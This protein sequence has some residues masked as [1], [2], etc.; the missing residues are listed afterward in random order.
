MRICR[1]SKIG[2]LFKFPQTSV[3]IVIT[4]KILELIVKLSIYNQY[5]MY[6]LKKFHWKMTETAV[7]YNAFTDIA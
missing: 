7:K 5:L 3:V 6:F 2:E 1:F 4:L